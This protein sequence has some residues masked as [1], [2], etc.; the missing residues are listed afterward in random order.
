[1]TFRPSDPAAN[2]I[3]A[4]LDEQGRFNVQLP[5]GEVQVCIDN[6][7]LQPRARVAPEVPIDLP[8]DVREKLGNRPPSAPAV[9]APTGKGK[10]VAIPE[11]YYS[12]ATSGLKFT[13]KPGEQQET[14]KLSTE[15][16]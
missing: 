5:C 2:S 7:E 4:E 11:K 16:R 12:I 8:P 10:Y 14:L 1:M 13:V 9:R 3:P 6:R 15:S